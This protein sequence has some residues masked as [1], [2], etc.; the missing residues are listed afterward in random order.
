MARAGYQDG[1]LGVLQLLDAYRLIRVTALRRLE[2]QAAV[3]DSEI[4]LSRNAGFEVT[5]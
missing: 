3:K 5:Q 2:L 4:E 1:E